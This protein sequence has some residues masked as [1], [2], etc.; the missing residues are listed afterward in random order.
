MK[1]PKYDSIYHF[2]VSQT[3][4]QTKPDKIAEF[5]EKIQIIRAFFMSLMALYDR[6]HEIKHN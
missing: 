2:L 4:E 1:K 5:T 3:G 6:T